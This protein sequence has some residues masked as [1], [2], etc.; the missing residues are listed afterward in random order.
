MV[1]KV[2]LN[3]RRIGFVRAV[4]PE[5]QIEHLNHNLLSRCPCR[6]VARRSGFQF[7]H[8]YRIY[9]HRQTIFGGFLLSSTF[10]P[11]FCSKRTVVTSVLEGFHGFRA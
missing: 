6:S 11:V 7:S 4:L 8:V 5:A 9:K 10:S 3:V 2:R 1:G